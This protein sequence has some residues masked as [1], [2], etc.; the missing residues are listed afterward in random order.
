MNT[1]IAKTDATSWKRLSAVHP[2]LQ[3]L[4]IHMKDYPYVDKMQGTHLFSITEGVR[5][6][7]RQKVLFASGASTTMESRHLTGHAVDVALWLDWD[8]DGDV[9]LR[10]DWPLY[11]K[12]ARGVKLTAAKLGIPI[13]WG[14]DWKTFKD[15]PHFELSKKV[16]PATPVSA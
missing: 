3:R 6:L 1:G 9:D 13:V 7:D 15:G 11:E 10:W 2:E 14:G 5:T 12:F 16:Y 4:F 8:G